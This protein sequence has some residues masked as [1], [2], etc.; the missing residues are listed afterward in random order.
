VTKSGDGSDRQLSCCYELVG[1]EIGV[2]EFGEPV[3]VVVVEHLADEDV[4]KRGKPLSS[5]RVL[6]KSRKGA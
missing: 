6:R 3:S 5:S 1:R 4:A 2:N